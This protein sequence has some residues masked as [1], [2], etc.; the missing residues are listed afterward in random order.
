MNIIVTIGIG[1]VFENGCDH[2]DCNSNPDCNVMIKFN[3]GNDH[4]SDFHTNLIIT[5][6]SESV[7]VL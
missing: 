5:F 4:T 2:S 3:C 7:H 6:R 1:L